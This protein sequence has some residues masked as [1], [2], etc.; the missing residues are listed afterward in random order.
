MEILKASVVGNECTSY[1]KQPIGE[2]LE[3]RDSRQG[4]ICII[5]DTL[6]QIDC[7]SPSMIVLIDPSSIEDCKTETPSLRITFEGKANPLSILRNSLCIETPPF[8]FRGSCSGFPGYNNKWLRE[9]V[10]D[11]KAP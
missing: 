7:K 9:R 1:D 8:R 5:A 10:R 4:K 2:D 3:P 6:T 11:D